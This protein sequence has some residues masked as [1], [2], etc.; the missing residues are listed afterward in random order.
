MNIDSIVEITARSVHE[1]WC[2]LRRAE[3][4]SYGPERNDRTKQTP[5][6]VPYDELPESEKDYDRET[7]RCVI[8]SLIKAGFSI[9][10][11]G[12]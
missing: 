9:K 3:G 1:R 10:K 12:P 2:S 5:C 7:T 11:E 6:L 8:E 4:W